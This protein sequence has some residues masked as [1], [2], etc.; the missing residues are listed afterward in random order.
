LAIRTKS[1]RLKVSNYLY[2]SPFA[3]WVI[4]SAIPAREALAKF[5]ANNNSLRISANLI[6]RQSVLED[7]LGIEPRYV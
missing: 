1:D 4:A 5:F 3:G 2:L 6:F 7:V